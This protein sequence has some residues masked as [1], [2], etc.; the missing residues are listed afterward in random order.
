MYLKEFELENLGPIEYLNHKL[1]FSNDGNPK[2][3]LIIGENGAGKSILISHIVNAIISARQTVF[4][5]SDVENGKVYKYR[6]PHYIKSG[7]TFSKSTIKFEENFS[8]SE[9]QL[10]RSKTEFENLHQFTSVDKE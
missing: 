8:L 2:A 3:L 1:K 4:D 6:S 10:E 9:W 7:K 5:D